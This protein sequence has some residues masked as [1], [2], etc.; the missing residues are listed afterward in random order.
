MFSQKNF[1][2]LRK[3][4]R[5]M[6]KI[7]FIVAFV[8]APVIFTKSFGINLIDDLKA[9]DNALASRPVIESQ[10]RVKIDSLYQAAAISNMAYDAYY[11]LYKEYRSYNYDT[12]LIYVDFMERVAAPGQ[13][14]EVE[15]CRAFVYLSGG[16]FKE[17]SDILSSWRERHMDVVDRKLLFTYRTM[18]ARLQWDMADN[19]GGKIGEHYNK[20]GLETNDQIIQSLSTQD[21]VYYWYALAIT[22]LREGN[23]ARSIARCKV[24]LEA[25]PASIHEQAITASTLAYLY[26][27]TNEPEKALHYYIEA[28]ICDILSSTYETVALRNVAELLFE[29]GETDLADRYIHIAMHDA[30]RYHA[31]HRQVD[32]AQS[33]PIIEEQMMSRIRSQQYMTYI[34]LIVVAV[35]L[36]IGIIGIIILVRQNRA[37]TNAQETID[38]MNGSLTEANKLKEQLLGTLLSSRSKYIN[39]VKQYQQDVKQHAAYRQWNALFSIPKDADARIQRV[40]L[41]H[42]IDTI[43]LSIYPTF[44]EDFNSLLRPEEQFVLKKDEL[45]NTQLRIFAL[46]RLGITHN[47]VIAEILD[48]S[49]NTVYSYKTRVIASSKM[50]ADEFYSSLMQIPSFSSTPV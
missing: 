3:I 20:I 18:Y 23:Y 26:R 45:L 46:I 30:Q 50:K 48:Y 21:T 40:V 2:S 29:A 22:D 6:K 35:L 36:L 33:L 37:L 12:A 16:L 15:L 32:I 5:N 31:R 8:T 38:R 44:I 28:A 14:P 11:W 27:L 9:L 25:S 7:L 42:Q 41:D 1:V 17:A 24:S 43:F 34:L 19:A 49:I 39:A 10:K 4:L 47:E 13:L